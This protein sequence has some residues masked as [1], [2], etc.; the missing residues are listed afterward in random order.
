MRV[1]VTFSRL[2][3]D[4]LARIEP[5]KRCCRLAELSGIVHMDGVLH[6]RGKSYALHTVTEN[7]ATARKTIK[8]LAEL[9]QLKAEV[10]V[11]RSLL[12]RTN[13]YVVYI[14]PQPKLDQALNELGILDDSMHIKYG[15]LAR[16]A[17]KNCCAIAYLRG[18]FMGGGFISDPKK[19]HHFELT[20]DNSELSSDLQSLLN[21]FEFPAKISKRR[22]NFAI[23]LTEGASMA[24]FLALVGA[25]DALLKWEDIKIVKAMRNKV[26]RLVNCETANLSKT[27]EAALAQLRNIALIEEEVGLESIPRSLRE[28]ANVRTSYPYVSLSE[29]GTL[30]EPSISKVAVYHRIKRLSAIAE[31]LRDEK[32]GLRRVAN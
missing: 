24:R 19:E 16:I 20:T 30:C 2:V 4:E 22:R 32:R 1:A 21:R 23:Y 29:L 10:T 15:I 14:S 8:L 7:A 13:N 5:S 26:N 27:I 25:Y 9:F 17:R 11:R 6:I 28:I 12:H 3:K 31:G 18:S